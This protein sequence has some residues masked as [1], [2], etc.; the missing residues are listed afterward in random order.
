MIV[1]GL[2]NSF[3]LEMLDGLHRASHDYRIALYAERANLSPETT[4]YVT[5][6]EV[7]SS[8]AQ[9]N[10]TG[11]KAGGL[12]LSGRQSKLVG[13]IA[14]ATW[15]NPVWPNASITARAGLIYNASVS[16][17]AVAVVDLG[18]NFTSTNGDF[19]VTFPA[20]TP[21]SALIAFAS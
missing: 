9:G 18:K 2:V 19:R 16:N 21:E 10:P 20:F 5:L 14:L 4:A 8:D 15:D 1:Q 12:L 17:K 7:P 11:Y 13:G 6:G 3:K